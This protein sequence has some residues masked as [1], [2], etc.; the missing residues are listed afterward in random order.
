M[1]ES[2]ALLLGLSSSMRSQT[3]TT[4]SLSSSSLSASFLS[5][6]VSRSISS[7]ARALLNA[8]NASFGLLRNRAALPRSMKA[9]LFAWSTDRISSQVCMT[10]SYLFSDFRRSFFSVSIPTFLWETARAESNDARAFSPRPSFTRVRPSLTRSSGVLG[11]S[12]NARRTEDSASSNRSSFLSTSDLSVHA[13][14]S[15]ASA[16]MAA[17]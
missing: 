10:S 2:A 5:S 17:S 11:L 12:F 9:P 3:S 16:L 1:S 8:N 7:T 4:A 14:E 15:F 13:S 6:S